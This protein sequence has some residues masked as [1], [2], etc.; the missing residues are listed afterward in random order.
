MPE[1]ET[2]LLSLVALLTKELTRLI[3]NAS[4]SHYKHVT[5]KQEFEAAKQEHDKNSQYFAQFPTI[6]DKCTKLVRKT[7]DHYNH[8]KKAAIEH[9]NK[10]NTFLSRVAGDVLKKRNADGEALALSKRAV[11]VMSGLDTRLTEVSKKVD[12]T[13][14]NDLTR[15]RAEVQ[16]LK[17]TNAAMKKD[18]EDYKA[19][20]NKTLR[21][22]E[23]TLKT[24]EELQKGFKQDMTRMRDIQNSDRAD[25][26][27]LQAG[28]AK[29]SVD[30]GTLA[31]LK[32]KIVL[33]ENS[34]S[35]ARFSL[36]GGNA[37]HVWR[38]IADG[39]VCL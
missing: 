14:P 2:Q 10:L 32:H 27:K 15:L 28:S 38:I 30:G 19:E 31:D 17:D 39:C 26:I 4:Y 3:Q 12:A 21:G 25:L 6:K 20:N 7:E 23:Q 37:Q 18:F 1:Q 29:Q 13:S 5:A 35:Q 9:A 8:E 16:A 36:C 34:V 22:Y 24:Y 11:D 33:L